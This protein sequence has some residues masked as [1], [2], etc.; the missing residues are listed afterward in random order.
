MISVYASPL[1]KKPWPTPA[2]N[3]NPTISPRALIPNAPVLLASPLPLRPD[4]SL[5]SHA[6]YQLLEQCVAAY[7]QDRIPS[8]ATL[9]DKLIPLLRASPPLEQACF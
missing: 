9:R 8:A 6:V 3:D 7:P 4:A 1:A 5:R 2:L